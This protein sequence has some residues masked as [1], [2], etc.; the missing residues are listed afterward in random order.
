MPRRLLLL[1]AVLA[2]LA[3]APAHAAE[4]TIGS[5]LAAPATLDHADG[6][7]WVAWNTALP[8]GQLVQSPVQGEINLVRVKGFM[9]LEGKDQKPPDV[10]GYG[11]DVDVQVH[12]TVLRPQADGRVV[13]VG[14]SVS[15]NLPLPLAQDPNQIN[16]Y[17]RDQLD[18]PDG[19]DG[20]GGTR[21]CIQKGDYIGYA[22][23]GGFGGDARQNPEQIYTDG[24]HFQVFGA[25]RTR[26][27]SSIFNRGGAFTD[28]PF[29]ASPV[30][31]RELL[32]QAVIG[33][34]E[35]ARYTCRTDAEKKENL[36]YVKPA[37]TPAA[38]P[39]PVVGVARLLKP[40]TA[41]KVRGMKVRI[42]VVC[43]AVAACSG[44]VSLRTYAR[45]KA[46]TI[47]A[48]TTGVVELALNRTAAKKLKRKGARLT[49]KA[50]LANTTGTRSTLRFLIKRA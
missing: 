39:A 42:P 4:V 23:T 16:T 12:I 27:A 13:M 47:P 2:V 43:S 26:S 35:N 32:L 22:S 1:P 3:A 15:Q 25:V 36:D 45:S 17:T 40:R 44:T 50:M 18:K 11:S 28:S 6:N 34:R 46:F 29:G 8:D 9:Q 37:A 10:P 49:V 19:A 7:D 24:A 38:T 31:G 21:L 48:G 33:T 5:D 41:P 14:S 20:K 30:G